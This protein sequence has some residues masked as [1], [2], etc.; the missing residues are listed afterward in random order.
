MRVAW[1]R[2]LYFRTASVAPSHVG[3]L[4]CPPGGEWGGGGGVLA[5]SVGTLCETDLE[6]G[7]GDSRD[8]RAVTAP[9]PKILERWITAEL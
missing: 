8:R 1:I 2:R 9:Y 4:G 7:G 3:L 5:P 6:S